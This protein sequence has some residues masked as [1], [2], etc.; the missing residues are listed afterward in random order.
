M[1]WKFN[2]FTNG[3][4]NSNGNWIL[5]N[6]HWIRIGLAIL[7][8]F[9]NELELKWELS[10]FL[11]QLLFSAMNTLWIYSIENDQFKVLSHLCLYSII[12]WAKNHLISP[13]DSF[14]GFFNVSFIEKAYPTAKSWKDLTLRSSKNLMWRFSLKKLSFSSAKVFS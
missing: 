9:W 11:D 4:G 2:W 8:K 14:K 5:K 7:L 6:W 10:I 12:Y 13:K 3:N 1:N